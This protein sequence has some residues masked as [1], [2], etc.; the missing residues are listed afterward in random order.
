LLT[1]SAPAKVNL[2]LG[3]G[4]ARPDGYHAVR[5]VL[6]TI[7]LSDTVT[8]TPSDELSLACDAEL[9]IAAEDNLAYRACTSFAETFDVEVLLDVDLVKRIPSGAGLGGGSSDAAAVLAGLAHWAGLPLDDSRVLRV[10]AG[11]GADVPFLLRGGAA[12]MDGRGD[13]LVR[14]LAALDAP[15]VLVKPQVSVSTAEAYR[16]FDRDPQPVGDVRSVADALRS[17]DPRRLA[18]ALSNNMVAASVALAPEIGE[19][20]AW[21]RSQSGVLGATMAGSGSAAFGI[22]ESVEVCNRLSEQAAERGWWGS[23]TRLS[24]TGVTVTEM[25]AGR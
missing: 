6:H 22:C 3:V 16:A 20:L 5:T 24:P 21:L 2:F 7:A 10:A 25:E 4:A 1:V 15:L 19:A 14:P 18:S 13:E 23:P 17:R 11:L 8:L 12:L 9:G